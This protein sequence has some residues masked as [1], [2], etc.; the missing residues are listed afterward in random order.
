MEWGGGF[1]AALYPLLPVWDS[2]GTKY[3]WYD[4]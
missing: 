1:E 3:T 2:L 4:L